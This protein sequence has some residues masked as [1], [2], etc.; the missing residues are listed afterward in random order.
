MK[1]PGEKASTVKPL[2][3]SLVGNRERREGTKRKGLHC[4]T[5]S[6][7]VDR[8]E[9]TSNMKIPCEFDCETSN[10]FLYGKSR[11]T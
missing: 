10:L 11:A 2:T 1:T 5:S 4:R 6:F 8:G 9:G 3:S 7:V